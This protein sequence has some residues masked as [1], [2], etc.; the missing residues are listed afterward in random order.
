MTASAG[1]LVGDDA[2]RT[3]HGFSGGADVVLLGAPGAT[4]GTA[5]EASLPDVAASLAELGLPSPL[6]HLAGAPADQLTWLAEALERSDDVPVVVAAPDLHISHVALLDLLDRPGVRTAALVADPTAIVEGAGLAGRARVGRDGKQVESVGTAHHT[7]SRPDRALP[8]V[9]RVAPGDRAAAA[10]ALRTAAP[11][12]DPSWGDDGVAAATLVLVRA[13]LPVQASPLGPFDWSRGGVRAVGAAGGPWRQ[14]LRGASRGGDGFFSTYAVRPVSR[15]ITGFGLGHGWSPNVVTMVSLGLGVLAALLVATG[16]WWAWVVAAVV[17]LV[18]LAVDCVDGEIARFTRRFSPLGAFLDA[19][20]DRVKEYAVLAAV[21]S[22]AVREGA[23][24]W[25]VAL[26]AMAAV[27]VRHLED[28]AYEARLRPSRR[29][30]PDLLPADTPHDLGPQDAPTTFGPPPSRRAQAV[31]WSKKVVHMPIAE[32][33]LL[34]SLTLLTRRPMLVLWAL[35]VA[36]VVAVAW[37]QG[38]RVVAVLL[39]RDPTWGAVV[40]AAARG[41]LDEQLD[42]GPLARLVGR[43]VGPASRPPFVVGLAGA[44]VLVVAVPLLLWTGPVAASLAAAVVG[45]ALVALGWQPPVHDR[46]GWQAPAALWVAE[47]L[48]VGVLVHH[49]V[50][51]QTAAGFAYVAAV[52]YHRYDVVYRL[53]DT[54]TAPAAWLATAGLGTEGRLIVLLLLATFAPSAVVPVL[55][56]AAVLLA[57]LYLAESATGWRRWIAAQGD[58]LA[59]GAR[60]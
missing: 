58:P 53:R 33:Y 23:P 44:A 40:P 25:P 26:A 9:L 60:R 30:R 14:R 12:A 21:A 52:A 15:R 54:G 48:A 50:G 37:T 51:V 18:A 46:L 56:V 57:V 16:A 22:V 59:T 34:I 39:R 8:G 10:Q 24:G 13:G 38:G 45:S 2:A 5:V 28:Y 31:H 20:G 42:L 1:S 6:A 41:E 4:P 35:L 49:T 29:S 11:L 19:V 32:R 17:L 3:V 7:V 55:W 43:L 27:T 36:V 47:A